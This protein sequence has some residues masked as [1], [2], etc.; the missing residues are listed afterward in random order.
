V[1]TNPLNAATLGTIAIFEVVPCSGEMLE[2][3][4]VP[5][6]PGSE[7][8]K[9]QQSRA[10]ETSA[11]FPPKCAFLQQSGMF[12][13]GQEPSPSCAPTPTA[14]PSIATTRRKAVNNLRIA[15]ERLY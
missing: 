6:L 12:V 14:P 10:M 13:I 7:Q 1:S 11:A 9:L 3:L 5:L 2:E 4:L 8:F 15:A